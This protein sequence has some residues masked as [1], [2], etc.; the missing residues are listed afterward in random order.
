MAHKQHM[1]K[2]HECTDCH[3]NIVH[4]LDPK[5]HNLPSMW[6]CF[7]CHNDEDAPR[8][9]C[10]LCHLGQKEMWEGIAAKEVLEEPAIM[11]GEVDCSE[12]HLEEN[13]YL[14]PS[15]GQV[16]VDC[17]DD[18]YADML[19]DWQR[20][21][22]RKS[23][24]LRTILDELAQRMKDIKAAG[25]E[26]PDYEVA[27]DLF[28]KASYNANMIEHD[29]SKGVHNFDYSISI[30]NASLQWARESRNILAAADIY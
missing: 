17:H 28:D 12:C 18:S 10:G 13:D 26:V 19:K 21:V 25:T 3:I 2:G 14:P 7:K 20:E 30:L 24:T 23:F 6:T 1:D 9:D 27:R 5:G 8:E 11:L 16:C 29:G 22:K 4:G 15:K